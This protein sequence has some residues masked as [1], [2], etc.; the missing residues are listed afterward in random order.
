[1]S[2]AAA[3][4]LP[5]S[6]STRR[7]PLWWTLVRHEWRLTTRDFFNLA[8]RRKRAVG[9]MPRPPR[10]LVG[11]LVSIALGAILLHAFGLM[12]VALPRTWQDT[13][14]AR[15]GVVAA[16]AFL[17]TFLLSFSM[18]RIVAAF[19]ERRDLDLLLSAPIDPMTVLGIR[20]LAVVVAAT[21][22]FGIFVVPVLDVGV[23]TGHWWMARWYIVLPLMACVATSVALVTAD[24]VVRLVG[25]RRARVG[26]QIFSAFVG[27]SIYFV[28]Q[29]RSFLPG[30]TSRRLTNWFIRVTRVDD[31]PW[32]VATLAAIARGDA[33]AWAGFVALAVAS[34]CG[35]LLWSRRRFVEIAQTP[36]SSAPTAR[37]PRAVVERRFA[38]GFARKPF[39]TLVVK[40]WRLLLRAPQLISQV[41]LQLLY[42]MPLM[43]VAFRGDGALLQWGGAA[44]PAGITGIAGTLA[45]SL[46]WLTVL[47]EDAPDLLAGSPLGRATVLAAKLV[48]ASLPPVALVVLAAAGLSRRSPLDATIVLGF[49]TAACLSAA[50]LAAASPG[51]GKR[52]DFQSRHKGRR[53]SALVEALQFLLWAG[54]AGAAS[55]G[56]GFVAAGLAVLALAMPAWRLPRALRQFAD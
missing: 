15:L 7:P 37:R 30:E 22:T 44:L 36:D 23:A 28:S 48:A 14:T 47:A 39:A 24:V 21:T 45:A 26:L 10:G 42:L 27:A 55:A 31:A 53:L 56:H 25:V 18:S 4:E 6:T 1:M 19:H 43:F 2:D 16:V 17:G 12:A 38:T 11:R 33:L 8:G 5:W 49:G 51:G 20:T 54:A 29:A 50:V 34:F 41:L 52:T 40:E 35:A 3:A 9:S 46:A 13:A 32:P